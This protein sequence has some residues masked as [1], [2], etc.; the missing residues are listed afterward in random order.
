MLT[1]NQR[2][3]VSIALKYQDKGMELTDL[4]AEGMAGLARSVEKYDYSKGF[5]FSTYATWWVRQ[6]ISRAI[7]DLSKTIRYFIHQILQKSSHIPALLQVHG[8]A[9]AHEMWQHSYAFC[10]TMVFSNAAA[11]LTALIW[12]PYLKDGQALNIQEVACKYTAISL[13]CHDRN[14]AAEHNCVA[15][16]QHIKL[17]Q[18]SLPPVGDSWE[19]E[20]SRG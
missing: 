18:A 17:M 7:G 11:C 15:A 1:C 10:L 6:A 9:I 4:I 14:A 2:L 13:A 12:K 8:N 19:G 16:F 5:K 20:Q 3:V